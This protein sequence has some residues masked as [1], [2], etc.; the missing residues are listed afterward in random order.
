VAYLSIEPRNCSRISGPHFDQCPLV[1]THFCRARCHF[2]CPG[3]HLDLS[4]DQTADGGF[5]QSGGFGGRGRTLRRFLIAQELQMSD[6]PPARIIL[7]R[8]D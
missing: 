6:T 8:R 1:Q 5:L 7:I 3:T 4:Q 2:Q